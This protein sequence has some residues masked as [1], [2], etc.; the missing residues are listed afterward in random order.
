MPS[1]SRPTSGISTRRLRRR[2]TSESDGFGLISTNPT[3][4]VRLVDPGIDVVERIPREIPPKPHAIVYLRIKQERMGPTAQ[5]PPV[6]RCTGQHLIGGNI[7]SPKFDQT[8]LSAMKTTC[9]SHCFSTLNH[10]LAYC[11]NDTRVIKSLCSN[12]VK[13]R[14]RGGARSF[15][16]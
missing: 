9:Q 4:S 8:E 10:N 5:W 16:D 13:N 7:D 12:V 3:N 6:S 1:A 11:Y 2:V 14:F 15:E